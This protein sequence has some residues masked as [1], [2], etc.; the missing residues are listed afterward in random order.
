MIKSTRPIEMLSSNVLW[1]FLYRIFNQRNSICNNHCDPCF[2][3][4]TE[5]RYDWISIKTWGCFISMCILTVA[6]S[7][8]CIIF[9]ANSKYPSFICPSLGRFIR[10]MGPIPV[11][12][13]LEQNRST[14]YYDLYKFT[15]TKENV[16]IHHTPEDSPHLRFLS[17]LTIIVFS[18]NKNYHLKNAHFLNE[19]KK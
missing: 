8:F 2:G 7:S 17:M 9:S 19:I 11:L 18:P 4:T 15:P 1:F 5:A 6:L 10:G 12:M 3:E 14:H 16:T 13:E